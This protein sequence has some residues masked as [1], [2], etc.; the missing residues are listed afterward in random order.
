LNVRPD[1]GLLAE[2]DPILRLDLLS[3]ALLVLGQREREVWVDVT[4]AGI[5]QNSIASRDRVSESA[6]AHCFRRAQRKVERALVEEAR[7]A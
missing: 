3:A 1:C 5:A 7:A 2:I 6:V 4:I